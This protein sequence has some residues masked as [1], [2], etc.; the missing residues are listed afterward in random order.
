M[1]GVDGAEMAV[2]VGR[3]DGAPNFALRHFRVRP[4]GHT[5][6]H[7]HDYEH[8]VFIVE[9]GGTVLLEGAERPIRAGDVI[10]IPADEEHQFQADASAGLRFLC[11][12]PVTRN[13]GESTPGS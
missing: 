9:G 12:V 4:G 5:P 7:S 2:M 6:R 3:E 13:C 11:L 8:E 10:Y 1:P